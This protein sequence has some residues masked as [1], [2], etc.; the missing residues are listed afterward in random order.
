MQN[1]RDFLPCPSP[2][3]LPWQLLCPSFLTCF[4]AHLLHHQRCWPQETPAPSDFSCK[5]FVFMRI[6]LHTWVCLAAL[7]PCASS[8]LLCVQVL[9]GPSGLR[10]HSPHSQ[11][12]HNLHVHFVLPL[13]SSALVFHLFPSTDLLSLS[14]VICTPL[15]PLRLSS[16][17]WEFSVPKLGCSGVLL[18]NIGQIGWEE[19]RASCSPAPQPSV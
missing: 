14:P 2:D 10:K 12:P 11:M 17:L 16:A 7:D 5:K 13:L 9:G 6:T 3:L 1:C 15:L 4:S 18:E 8:Q 19:G